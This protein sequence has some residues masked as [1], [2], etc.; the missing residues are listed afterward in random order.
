MMS[1]LRFRAHDAKTDWVA[2]E[3][4]IQTGRLLEIV[5]H[6]DVVELPSGS[7]ERLFVLSQSVALQ[8]A[9]NHPK[10]GF[11]QHDLLIAS[12]EARNL[13]R[14]VTSGI[15]GY[16]SHWQHMQSGHHELRGDLDSR[17]GYLRKVLDREIPFWRE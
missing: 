7:F 16:S 6:A 15:P 13:A 4:Y 14:I 17:I 2:R 12:P 10:Y 9:Q 8:R 1:W 3:S 5:D 11:M